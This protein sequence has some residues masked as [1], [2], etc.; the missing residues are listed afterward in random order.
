VQNMVKAVR[1]GGVVVYPTETL[2]ALGCDAFHEEAVRRVAE[3]KGRPEAKPLPLIVGDLAGL[4]RV[5]EVLARDALTLAELFWP[6]PLSILVRSGPQLPALV[7]DTQGFT[8]VRL[9]ANPFAAE[10]CRLAETA[11]V[12]TSANRSGRPAAADPADLDPELLAAV[13]RAWL[14]LPRPSGGPPSTVVRCLGGRR[15]EIVRSGAVPPSAL[16]AAGFGT[17]LRPWVCDAASARKD[18]LP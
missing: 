2:Y 13:D 15:I 6:G 18:D 8:S 16:E 7:K 4:A 3:I 14:D 17:V 9:S 11:L 1:S 5:T 10:L 12:A